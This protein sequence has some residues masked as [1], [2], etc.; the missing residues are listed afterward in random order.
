[1]GIDV[2]SKELGAAT[3]REVGSRI[4]TRH[5]TLRVLPQSLRAAANLGCGAAPC[6]RDTCTVCRE[7]RKQ[8]RCGAKRERTAGHSCQ[9]NRNRATEA[10]ARHI[11]LIASARQCGRGT[12]L[13][14]CCADAII[15]RCAASTRC[16]RALRHAYPENREYVN[17]CFHGGIVGAACHEFAV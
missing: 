8:G 5:Q 6:L 4:V 2:N 15:R 12:R 14:I 7:D 3:A 10:C 17:N 9:I 1:M 11:G 16:L 13:G